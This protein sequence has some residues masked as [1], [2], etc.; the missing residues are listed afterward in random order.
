MDQKN[1]FYKVNEVWDEKVFHEYKLFSS[2]NVC[3][4]EIREFPIC[5]FF[6]STEILMK[7]YRT[8]KRGISFV[9]IS[10][11]IDNISQETRQYWNKKIIE[12][13]FWVGN[14]ME[15]NQGFSD[16]IPNENS[17]EIREIRHKF[18][19]FLTVSQPK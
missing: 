8:W 1:N 17:I 4:Q 11:I 6:V 16:G 18:R 12:G 5:F 9:E 3:R 10:R 2:Q 19:K 7:W 13:K 14:S 15:F